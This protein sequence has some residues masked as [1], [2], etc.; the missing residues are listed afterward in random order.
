MGLRFH[1]ACRKIRGSRCG[2][3]TLSVD[4]REHSGFMYQGYS[5]R[6]GITLEREE[7]W[8]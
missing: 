8:V 3:R 1:G 4:E 2:V 6:C 7:F 5:A